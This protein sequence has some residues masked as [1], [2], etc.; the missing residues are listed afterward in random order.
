M[1]PPGST[2]VHFPTEKTFR[3]YK[4]EQGEAYARARP[5]Y[6][7][8]LYETV[9]NWHISTGGRLDTLL[10]VGCGPG[11]AARALAPRFAHAIG[12]DPSEGMIATARAVGGVSSSSKPVRFEV[13][14]AEELGGNLSPPVQDS[15]VDLIIAANAAHWFDMSGF[16]PSAARV[17]KPGGSVA[18]WTTGQI[19]T[20]PSMPNAAAIQ[21]AI[22]QHQESHLKPYYTPGSILAHNRYVDLPLPWMLE[23]PVPEFDES[24]FFRKD[25]DD[26]EK[27]V[28]GP[29]EVDLDIFEKLMATASNVTRWREAHP[30]DVGTERDVLRILRR[31]IERLLHEAG[32][33]KG[34]EKLKGTVHGA[35]LMVKKKA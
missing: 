35:L 11:N 33:E 25:W 12:L 10:D 17:L 20:H 18:L 8:F 26:G 28:V 2:P 9:I 14:T 4:Q 21:A 31:E 6:H 27:F 30:D 16:W 34:K 3:S 19:R 24:T 7:P 29:S 13:S 32:V 22:E 15:S 23:Q 1:A 5:D